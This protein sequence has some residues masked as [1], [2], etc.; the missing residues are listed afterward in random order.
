MGHSLLA[1]FVYYMTLPRHLTYRISIQEN[2]QR[3]HYSFDHVNCQYQQFLLEFTNHMI[4]HYMTLC[5]KKAV[6]FVHPKVGIYAFDISNSTKEIQKLINLFKNIPIQNHSSESCSG[7]H[8]GP[9]SLTQPD[10]KSNSGRSN[11]FVP[12]KT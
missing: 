11:V 10:L 4:Q 8:F 1:L 3:Y 6:R 9:T 2:N 5:V 7:P 12:K